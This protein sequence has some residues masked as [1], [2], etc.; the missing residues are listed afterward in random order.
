MR[1]G[2]IQPGSH[3]VSGTCWR[4]TYDGDL[5][6]RLEAKIRGTEEG[7]FRIG[8]AEIDL[9]QWINLVSCPRHFGG[10][11][12]YFLT[13]SLLGNAG[14]AKLPTSRSV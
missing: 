9:D 5:N 10:R 11:Q 8:I 1:S 3:T 13:I 14:G 2:A 4:N 6:A 7:W 12:W